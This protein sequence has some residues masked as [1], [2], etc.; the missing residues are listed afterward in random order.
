MVAVWVVVGW[1]GVGP[2]HG[3]LGGGEGARFAHA[4]PW[5]V[6]RLL[7]RNPLTPNSSLSLVPS[8]QCMTT[9]STC[10]SAIRRRPAASGWVLHMLGLL[11][12]M[13]HTRTWHT[14]WSVVLHAPTAVLWLRA[15]G[16][17]CGNHPPGPGMP[18]RVWCVLQEGPGL[19]FA[20]SM[21]AG[22]A[23]AFTTAPVDIVKTR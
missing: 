8:P 21:V 13:P 6:Q 1:G 16:C 20:C 9:Q 15:L 17:L 3:L 2:V 10:C 4:L 22:F 11:N 14:L 23:C 19:H 7:Q 18:S 5:R 12:G